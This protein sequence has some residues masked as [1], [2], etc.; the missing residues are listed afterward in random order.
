[1]YNITAQVP[2]T[3]PAQK[4]VTQYTN[5]RQLLKAVIPKNRQQN[6]TAV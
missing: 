6:V 2:V 5:I 1:M 3:K 4:R